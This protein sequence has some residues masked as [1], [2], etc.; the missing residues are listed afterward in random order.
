MKNIFITILMSLGCTLASG[1]KIISERYFKDA[2]R[3]KET[4]LNNARFKQVFSVLE[5]GLKKAEVIEIKS[6]KVFDVKYF[7]DGKPTGLWETRGKAGE[8]KSCRNFSKLVY[9]DVRITDGLY[10]EYPYDTKSNLNL[11]FTPAHFGT[12]EDHIRYLMENIRYPH[13][14]MES[15]TQGKVILHLKITK[16]GVVEVISISKGVDPY[17]D[18]ESWRVIEVMPKWTPAIKD[19][20]PVDSYTFIPVSYTLANN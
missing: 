18:L 9:S 1:Q 11:N 19:G 3:Y 20:E 8:I 14:A 4:T 17:L 10:F 15:G 2:D 13:E 12:Q 6:G 7:R 5:D 16:D